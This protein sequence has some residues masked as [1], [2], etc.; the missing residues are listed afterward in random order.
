MGMDGCGASDRRGKGGD[1]G[2]VVPLRTTGRMGLIGSAGRGAAS[3]AGG[4]GQMAERRACVVYGCCECK[5]QNL[6]S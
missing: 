5:E 6:F 4:M 3:G 1:C 2:S